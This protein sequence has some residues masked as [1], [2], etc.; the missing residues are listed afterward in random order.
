MFTDE[1]RFNLSFAG[2]RI[3]VFR[4]RGERFADNCLLERDR[5]GGGSVMV[6]GGIMGGRKTDLIVITGILNAQHYITEL[7]GPVVIPFLNQNPGIL[8]H[9]N[10][11]PHTAR[12]TQNYLA[13]HNVNVLQWPASH[14]DVNPIEHV[15]DVLGRRARENHV[16]NNINNLRATLSQE[17]NVIPND[18]VR[19]YVRSMRS[20]MIAVIRRR[21]GHTWY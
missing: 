5:F 2:G 1:S 6:W 16:I 19:R 8:M 11:R 7:L 13:R 21:G 17:W 20:R 4:R 12:L 10:A 18:V 14:P 15:W 9:D 3:R